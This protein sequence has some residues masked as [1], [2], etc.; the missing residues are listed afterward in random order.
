MTIFYIQPGHF[1][2][3]VVRNHDIVARC[4]SAQRA[5]D[6]AMLLTRRTRQSGEEATFAGIVTE[7]Y[8]TTLRNQ[9]L[10]APE[11]AAALA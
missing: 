1:A 4:T 7:H 2:W 5:L 9:A 10:A 6:F 8:Q 3:L 11:C